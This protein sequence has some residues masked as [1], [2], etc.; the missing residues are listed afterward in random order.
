MLSLE[1]MLCFLSLL[2][3]TTT[4]QAIFRLQSGVCHLFRDILAKK[5]FVE[6]QTPK[7]IS[8]T[9]THSRSHWSDLVGNLTLTCTGSFSITRYSSSTLVSISHTHRCSVSHFLSHMVRFPVWAFHFFT[10]DIQIRNQP[11]SSV[12]T[13]KPQ[14]LTVG[15][16]TGTVFMWSQSVHED[17]TVGESVVVLDQDQDLNPV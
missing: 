13:Y 7:I 1:H 17:D 10:T 14:R 6:I 12:E 11:W 9:N 3:K 5:G 2:P 16:N 8:G 4:S 15:F